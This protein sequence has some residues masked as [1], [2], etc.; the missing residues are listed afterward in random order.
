M[1]DFKIRC[2]ILI[3][4]FEN[5]FYPC[6]RACR[7]AHENRIQGFLKNRGLSF[8]TLDSDFRDLL[9]ELFHMNK[10]GFHGYLVYYV[11]TRRSY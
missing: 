4:F 1:W 8:E 10:K 11:C 6:E 2:V 3:F 5:F 9:D 7:E